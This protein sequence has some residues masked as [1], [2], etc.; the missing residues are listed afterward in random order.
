MIMGNNMENNKAYTGLEQSKKL[1]EI[2]PIEGADMEYILEQWTDEETH[3]LKKG[4]SEVPVVKVDDD[5]PFQIITLPCWSLAALI[6]QLDETVTTEDGDFELH[7]YVENGGYYVQY[8]E[9][10]DGRILVESGFQEHLID[11][12]YEVII[13]LNELEY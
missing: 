11:A 5:S 10:Y 3:R 6:E 12:V 9:S 2:L 13:K 4:Y 1:A 8:D 7:I